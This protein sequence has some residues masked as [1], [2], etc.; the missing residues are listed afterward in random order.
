MKDDGLE[1]GIKACLPTSKRSK[2]LSLN[3][4]RTSLLILISFGNLDPFKLVLAGTTQ[5]A[6]DT[7]RRRV[8]SLVW[9]VM[10]SRILESLLTRHQWQGFSVRNVS[11]PEHP[12]LD[13]IQGLP[14]EIQ[15]M[16]FENL[17]YG[18]AISLSQVNRYY[19][20]IVDPQKAPVEVKGQFIDMMQLYFQHNLCV[21]EGWYPDYRS[22]TGPCFI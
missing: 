9:S 14:P 12:P 4:S 22:M 3:L 21:V 8:A 13:P 7:L 20:E 19:H 10:R 17:D 2:S 5:H 11:P 16:V 18:A 6:M 1:G 15:L